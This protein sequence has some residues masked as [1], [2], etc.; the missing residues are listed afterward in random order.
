MVTT[1]NLQSKA[2]I[3]LFLNLTGK[4]ENGYHLLESFFALLDLYD[5][6][7]IYETKSIDEVI[8]TQNSCHL[9]IDDNIVC[10]VLSYLR[11]H[12]YIDNYFKIVIEKNI[13]L[14]G[15]LGGSSTN[16]AAVLTS[17]N[18]YMNLPE[19]KLL[20]IGLKFGADV[21]F[22]I[23]NQNAFVSGIGENIK[24]VKLGLN[25]HL[26]IIKPDFAIS[27]KD[28]Y[29]LGFD[30][31]TNPIDLDLIKDQIMFGNN[32][33]EKNAIKLNDTIKDILLEIKE[34]VGCRLSRMTGSGSCCFGIF[35]SEDSAL[36]AKKYFDE[37]FWTY[38][39]LLK[40]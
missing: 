8:V 11:E 23:K 36:S 40:C 16:A 13:P 9:K 4:R 31:F 29:Q 18:Q 3:N 33:L 32:D 25:V 22:F 6:V 1:L 37:K 21:P 39:Q 5:L 10:K 24:P 26:L 28:C 27:S 12:G 38:Y 30:K 7:S 35:E 15:G 14:G 20:E 19:H 2:K 34:R 17:L